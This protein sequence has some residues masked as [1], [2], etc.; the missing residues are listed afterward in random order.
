MK[1]TILIFAV[2]LMPSISSAACVVEEI[3]GKVKAVCDGGTAPVSD[4]PAT[5]SYSR[6]TTAQLQDEYVK[7]LAE[8]DAVPLRHMSLG[9]VGIA[10]L[11]QQQT[12][13]SYDGRIKGLEKLL[14][15]RR[16]QQ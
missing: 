5:P 9:T 2:L 6:M 11:E 3:D 16:L 7:L 10:L 14:N 1:N 12:R 15:M 8:R 4:A 13:K